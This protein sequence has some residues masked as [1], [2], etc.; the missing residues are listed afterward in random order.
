MATEQ[1]SPTNWYRNCHLHISDHYGRYSGNC[2]LLGPLARRVE[3]SLEAQTGHPE[4]GPQ[5]PGGQ[6][7]Q[8]SDAAI[9][10]SCERGAE[11]PKRHSVLRFGISPTIGLLRYGLSVRIGWGN[12]KGSRNQLTGLLD[13][14]DFHSHLPIVGSR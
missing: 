10:I 13:M 4:T 12:W 14:V 9:D 3:V 2:V 11:T 1:L 5:N 8:E 7:E 6:S